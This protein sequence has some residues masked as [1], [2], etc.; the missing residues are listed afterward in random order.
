MYLESLHDS[1]VGFEL[2]LEDKN[3]IGKILKIVLNHVLLYRKI[4]KGDFPMSIDE[5]VVGWTFFSSKK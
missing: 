1:D 5:N 3:D 2:F 4:D